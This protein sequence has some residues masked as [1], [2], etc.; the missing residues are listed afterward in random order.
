[1]R[2]LLD[3]NALLWLTAEPAVLSP[4][5]LDAVTDP[6]ND[7]AFSA[8]SIW[9]LAIKQTAGGLKI[10]PDFVDALIQQGYSPLSITVAHGLAA[11]QLPMHHRDPFDRMLVAQ[12]KLEDRTLITRDQRLAAY[13]VTLLP[14]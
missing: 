7:V 4:P 6:S 8:A 5:T 14:A 9:E 2:L 12:A 13:D 10:P 1:M 11:A 3:S